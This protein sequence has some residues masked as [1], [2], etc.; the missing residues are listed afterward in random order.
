MKTIDAEREARWRA[1]FEQLGYRDIHETSATAQLDGRKLV[2][3]VLSDGFERKKKRESREQ[4]SWQDTRRTLIAA[5]LGVII[6][7]LTL[8]ASIIALLK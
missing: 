5:I 3:N 7:V 1:E 4:Q 8:I 2:D 6:G